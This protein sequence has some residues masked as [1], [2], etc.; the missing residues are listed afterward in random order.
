MLVVKIRDLRGKDTFVVKS[1]GLY[2]SVGVESRDVP[3]VGLAGARLLTSGRP[4][5]GTGYL[6]V[7]GSVV[8]A[9]VR[10]RCM[11]RARSWRTWRCAWPWEPVPVGCVAAALPGRG[12][13]CWVFFGEVLVLCFRLPWLGLGARIRPRSGC[14]ILGPSE[15]GHACISTLST[16]QYRDETH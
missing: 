6:A 11:I 14:G 9:G 15:G 7:A 5:H 10:G 3:A 12:L 2:P 16:R 13:A 4:G 1:T 8:V